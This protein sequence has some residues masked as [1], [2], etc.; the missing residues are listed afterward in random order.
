LT[1]LDLA[2]LG[3]AERAP[4]GSG[5]AHAI[6]GGAAAGPRRDF[7]EELFSLYKQARRPGL[8]EISRAV[9]PD[10]RRTAS[11]ETIRRTLLGIRG[12]CPDR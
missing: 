4:H 3:K 7:A 10:A 1:W 5:T 8:R 12:L 11:T 9:L 6:G 2:G